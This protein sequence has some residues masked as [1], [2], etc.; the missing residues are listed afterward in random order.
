MTDFRNQAIYALSP[1]GDWM[2]DNGN[3]I[4]CSQNVAQPTEELINSKIQEL[5]AAEPMRLLRLERN[6]KLAET[7]W[8]TLKAYSQGVEVPLTWKN[9]M[10]ALRDLPANSKPQLDEF[11]NLTNVAWPEIPNE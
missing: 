2:W 4:W 8:V 5:E 10:Q 11:G 6:L 7:D 3:L 9:Y 1:N